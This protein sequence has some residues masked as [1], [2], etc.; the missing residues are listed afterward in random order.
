MSVIYLSLSCSIRE[1]PFIIWESIVVAH[2]LLVAATAAK[3]H[4]S[5]STLCDP[6]DGSPS[7]SSV[8]GILQA[9]I[10]EWVVI[11]FS[12]AWKWKVKVKSLS[13]GRLFETP[14]T[15]AYQAPLSMGVSRQQYWRELPLSSPSS[16]SIRAQLLHGMWD[17]TCVPCT[18]GRFLTSGPPGESLLLFQIARLGF[19][20]LQSE[21]PWPT[22]WVPAII[23]LAFNLLTTSIGKQLFWVRVVDT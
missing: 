4:Q 13:H 19:C 21:E 16:C 9:R 17:Q 6:I 10:L 2:R 14:W 22:S 20:C 11:S 5:C 8:S 18:E 15:V 7:G 23:L 3:L 1:L 12:N